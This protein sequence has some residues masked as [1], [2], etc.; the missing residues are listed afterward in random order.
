MHILFV[1]GG[2][3]DRL[4]AGAKAPPYGHGIAGILVIWSSQG[5]L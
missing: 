1:G 2:A 3:N 4:G 5:L